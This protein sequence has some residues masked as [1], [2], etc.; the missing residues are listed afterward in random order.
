L[1]FFYPY[2]LIDQA[3]LSEGFRDAKT[4]VAAEMLGINPSTLRNRMN[5][6]GIAYGRR[7]KR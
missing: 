7:V 2:R 5:Q 3:E 4:N 6:L 1:L